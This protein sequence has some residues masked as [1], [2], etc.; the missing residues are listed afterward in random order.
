MSQTTLA[1][2]ADSSTRHLSYLETGRSRPSRDMVLRL[3][4]QLNLSLRDQ[5]LLLLAAGFAPAFAE[6]SLEEMSSARSAMEQ[7]LQVHLPYPAY[8]LDRHW[9][10]VLSNAA[11]PQLYEG[12]SPELLR[13]PVNAVRL[14]LH[15][16]GMGPRVENFVE[17]RAHTVTVL[18]QQLQARADPV[19]QALLTEVLSYPAPRGAMALASSEGPQRYAS[20]LRLQTRFGSVSFLNTTTVFGA[21]ADVTL[22][23]LALEML[24]PADAATIAIVKDMV[25]ETELSAG[26]NPL[27]SRAG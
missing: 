11:L 7:I 9:N 25:D 16:D 15:P 23:E 5:N 17:W 13:S 24:F 19:I 10:V 3:G 1:L 12:C 21:P 20:P 22:S 27:A 26:G 6:R 2:A 8:V 14:T 4:E 18:K